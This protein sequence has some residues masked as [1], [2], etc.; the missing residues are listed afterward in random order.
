MQRLCAQNKQA[1]MEQPTS[2]HKMAQELASILAH[3]LLLLFDFMYHPNITVM[4]DWVLKTSFLLS[5]FSYNVKKI[6]KNTFLQTYF[7]SINLLTLVGYDGTL[8]KLKGP[9]VLK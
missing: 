3:T 1:D 4:A 7:E 8:N 5:N 2:A 6:N 9:S